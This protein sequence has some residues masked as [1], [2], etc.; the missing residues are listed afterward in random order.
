VTSATIP[1]IR[2]RV[3]D[4][5]QFASIRAIEL[6]EGAE[7]GVRALALSTGGGLDAWIMID[8]SFDIGPVWHSGRPVAW[9]SAAGFRS[10]FLHDGEADGGYG[11]NRGFGGFLVTCGLEHIRGATASSPQHGR[12]PFTPARLLAHGEDWERDEPILFCEGEV[13]QSRYQG[14]AFRLHRRIEAPIG[15]TELR[16][17]DVIENLTASEQAHAVLY[18]F[19]LGW[20]AIDDGSRVTH[21]GVDIVAPIKLADPQ[22]LPCAVCRPVAGKGW[23]SCDVVVLDR[24]SDIIR[25]GFDAATLPFLQTWH[26]LRPR[27]GVLSIEPCTSMRGETGGSLGPVRL[28]ARERRRYALSVEFGAPAP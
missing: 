4:P 7:R 11:F 13:V 28:G 15:G 23:A 8:R 25:F 22:A 1:Q 16:I 12:L 20:P 3:G 9:Q 21:A 27:A 10:A 18:H 5:R 14:E 24:R 6:A 19:N 17:S 2:E 26:D